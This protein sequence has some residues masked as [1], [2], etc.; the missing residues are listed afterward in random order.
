MSRSFF[1]RKLRRYVAALPP[2]AFGFM[3]SPAFSAVIDATGFTVGQT[4]AN[5]SNAAVTATSGSFSKV[6]S[7]G[8]GATTVVG[9][10]TGFVATEA[11]I[12]GELF[13]I[14]FS[15]G[16][17]VVSEVTLGLLFTQGQ[18]GG[19]ANEQARLK[20]TT[21]I[22]GDCSTLNCLL[23]ADGTFKNLTAGVTTLSPGTEG[24]GGIFKI[25]N[26]FGSTVISKL[27]LLPFD[28]GGGSS[29]ANSDFGLV[30]ITYTT[31]PEPGTLALLGLGSLGLALAERRRANRA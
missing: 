20:P 2:L 6:T 3:G 8:T 24:Q 9:I 15:G 7:V 5:F 27:E 17:A 31:V 23:A 14:N 10:S 21:G 4:S 12:D 28:V 18:W 30:S 29:G 16:G 13:T 19:A 22:S 1:L 25:V 26:P 11:D